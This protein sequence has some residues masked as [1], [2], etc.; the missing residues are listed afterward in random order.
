MTTS[1]DSLF[2]VIICIE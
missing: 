2:C 1:S